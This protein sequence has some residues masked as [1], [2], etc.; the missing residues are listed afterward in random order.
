MNCKQ[1][2]L[3]VVVR[4]RANNEGRVL[5][6]LRLAS[7][8]EIKAENFRSGDWLGAVWVTDA[9][10]LRT[11]WGTT[12]LLP[13]ARLRPL[14]RD[15]MGGKNMEHTEEATPGEVRSSEG[16]GCT[17]VER[18]RGG[19]VYGTN[20]IALCE[21][22]AAELDRL[23]GLVELLEAWQREGEAIL[24]KNNISAA[25]TLGRW[26]ADRPWR[27]R[28]RPESVPSMERVVFWFDN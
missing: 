10:L 3:A 21:E 19:G 1:G 17:L 28:H 5:T 16:L 20:R 4:S 7:A 27:V 2:D 13:D 12:H 22:A 11:R 6:C 23:N 15:L 8:A 26:W 25:F 9:T 18:L 14:H 24:S